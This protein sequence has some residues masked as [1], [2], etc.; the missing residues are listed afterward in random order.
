MKTWNSRY[1][2]AG[3]SCHSSLDFWHKYLR[4]AENTSIL[5]IFILTFYSITVIKH[6]RHVPPRKIQ[7]PLQVWLFWLVEHEGKWS[8]SF[9]MKW[10]FFCLHLVWNVD[11]VM[12]H[13]GCC[14]GGSTPLWKKTTQG[15]WVP[16]HLGWSTSITDLDRLSADCFTR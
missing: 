9:K 16:V 14:W 1:L 12:S 8:M 5:L 6:L 13:L 10:P 2:L 4:G 15:F 3:Q 11:L 7:C